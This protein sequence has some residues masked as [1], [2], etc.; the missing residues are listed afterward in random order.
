VQ[1][2]LYQ[3]Y[4]VQLDFHGNKYGDQAFYDTAYFIDNWK[5]LLT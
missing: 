1:Y 5:K 3:G 4:Y 2:A